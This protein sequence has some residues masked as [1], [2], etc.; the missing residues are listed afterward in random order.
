M[1]AP[2]NRPI[3]EAI[4]TAGQGEQDAIP[5]TDD[6]FM[7]Q[8]V[9]NCYLVRTGDAALLVN[10]GTAQL[11][12][13]HR[14]R[15]ARVSDEPIHT[16][17]FT[18]SHPDHI[19]G[20][21]S[22]DGPDVETIAQDDYFHVRQYWND[23]GRFYRHRNGR[24]WRGVTSP[25]RKPGVPRPKPV[26]LDDPVP[27]TTFHDSYSFDVGPL[28]VDLLSVP[29][30]E[31]TDS[32]LVSLP[33]HRIVFSGNLLGPMW[34]QIPN[35]Y[36]VR[37]DKVRS[38]VRYVESVDRLRAL[39][40][41]ILI[42][43]HGEPIRGAAE[44]QDGLTRLR[45]AVEWVHDETITAMNAGTDLFTIMRE[46]SPP[47][48]LTLGEAHGKVMWNVRAAWEEDAGW[49]RYESTTELY[50]VPPRAVWGDLVELAGAD[51]LAD[52]AAN[53]LDAG[54]PLEAL[55]LTDIVLGTDPD[56][57]RALE[58]SLGALEE[59]LRRSGMENLSETRW[60][61]GEIASTKAAI[62]AP[63]R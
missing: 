58:V 32:L 41:E 9:S 11:A 31:T 14:D 50:A 28:H 29:G 48:A 63:E 17:V 44:I 46:V 26:I 6:I 55:H 21:H 59:L 54:R 61:E 34:L 7:S 8:D 47:P 49:F 1:T 51:A 22:F 2:G 25:A 43:G 35:L 38:A 40:P 57:P 3:L 24:L 36:T 5:I 45:D 15:F 23:L 18:Q 39:N 10:T 12:T 16:I 4:V 56:H 20:W 52:R 62:G 13:A 33:E 60:L 19:G 37:G 27:T 53:H 42:T 30:G